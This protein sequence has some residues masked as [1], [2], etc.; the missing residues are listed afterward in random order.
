[1]GGARVRRPPFLPTKQRDRNLGGY[2]HALALKAD[3]TVVG[4]GD[5][6]VYETA[7]SVG[8]SNIIAVA[9]GRYY[10][11]ALISPSVPCSRFNRW[12][13]P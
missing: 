13:K 2:G 12:D 10:F 4:W 9:D 3:G 7:P 5:S 1:V 8:V 6:S 11:L